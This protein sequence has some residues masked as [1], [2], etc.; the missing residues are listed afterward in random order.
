[1][2]QSFVSFL[3]DMKFL[4]MPGG[5]HF[6]FVFEACLSLTWILGARK[7]IESSWT[8]QIHYSVTWNSFQVR[9]DTGP[10][11]KGFLTKGLGRVVRLRVTKNF[12]VRVMTPYFWSRWQAYRL[13]SLAVENTDKEWRNDYTT[14]FPIP[15]R[16]KQRRPKNKSK[17]QNETKQKTPDLQLYLYQSNRVVYANEIVYQLH[18][19]TQIFLPLQKKRF[20]FSKN[21]SD[22]FLCNIYQSWEKQER[23][24]DDRNDKTP[25]PFLSYCHL[26]G[27]PTIS[28]LTANR[29]NFNSKQ[30]DSDSP[31][32]VCQLLP[33]VPR[34][35]LVRVRKLC[36]CSQGSRR[37]Q[38]VIN[39]DTLCQTSLLIG[40]YV[41]QIKNE[42]LYRGFSRRPYW[43]CQTEGK[44]LI[45]QRRE[46]SLSGNANCRSPW[47]HL[48]TLYWCIYASRELP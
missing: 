4:I 45:S 12:Q 30:K 39:R 14:A 46:I 21:R 19:I 22:C 7:R 33:H 42:T 1:M 37:I 24:G 5:T 13:S 16:N 43:C 41:E 15:V 27:G 40:R 36:T 38:R 8:Y 10:F 26:R 6:T 3:L 20:L 48:K 34:R 2:N 32:D 9:V 28:T 17:K 18:Q 23:N 29:L 35:M 31:D 11:L 44:E 25:P 47:R